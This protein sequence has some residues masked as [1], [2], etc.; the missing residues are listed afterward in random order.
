MPFLLPALPAA[1]IG[2]VG[3]V[4]GGILGRKAGSFNP[5]QQQAGNLLNFNAENASPFATG[6]GNTGMN[7]L[8]QA[9]GTLAGPSN[10]FQQL[11]SGNQAATTQ[12]LAPDINRIRQQNQGILQATNSLAPRGAGRSG[13]LF[14]LPF[15]TSANVSGLY[16]QVRP[17]AAQGLTQIGGL[18][19]QL[20]LGAGG[21][22]ANYFNSGNYAAGLLGGLGNQ[23]EKQRTEAGSAI[24]G[25]LQS[26]LGK[27]NIPGG[28]GGGAG[29]YNDTGQYGGG[30]AGTW[31]P[32]SWG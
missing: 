17:Q 27:I 16:N 23:L 4:L 7:F 25:L 2:G 26:V 20:G 31:A 1:I 32:G 9:R 10:Y 29:G 13:T 30:G 24:G 18:L 21:L 8:N 14:N 3:S 5:T 22:G 28:G 6:F 12:A 15:Q 11:L 19:G